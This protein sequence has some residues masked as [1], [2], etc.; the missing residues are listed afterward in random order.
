MI[1]MTR[2]RRHWC[3]RLAFLSRLSTGVFPTR[4]TGNGGDI[5][6]TTGRLTIRDGGSVSSST[7]GHGKKKI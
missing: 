5:S 7:F 4:A 3:W 2:C 6:I 1:R